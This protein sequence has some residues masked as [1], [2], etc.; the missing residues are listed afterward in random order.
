MPETGLTPSFASLSFPLS[1]RDWRGGGAARYWPRGGE[2]KRSGGKL[3]FAILL[4][5]IA[6]LVGEPAPSARADQPA[7]HPDETRRRISVP[8]LMY[9]Y[10]SVPPPDADR[11]RLDLSV[12]PAHFAEQLA[13]L[14]R[15]GYTTI[16]LDDLYA[17]LS[18]GQPLPPRPV[19]LTF[20][21]GYADAYDHAFR[22]LRA[23]GMVGTFFVVT[24]WLDAR[25]PG[26]L[27]WEQARTMARAGMAIQSH[28][29]SH[30]DLSVGCDYDC[31][32]YQILGSVESIEAQIG[33]RPRF[34]CYPGGRYSDAV[35]TVVD[36]VGIAAA[37]TTHAG[38]RHLSEQP[39]LLPRV[40]IR[41]TTTLSEFKWLVETG[42]S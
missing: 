35:L 36:Q 15:S 1:N 17:A 11:Y 14:A 20:D 25:T 37:V 4:A 30:P 21:D 28:S 38:M 40:R 34:F 13:W 29:R 32:V 10:I 5:L 2:A 7:A 42:G 9:H 3:L 16:T 8:V 23:R 26:Y 18:E 22:L 19:A 31:L 33:V 12:T 39:L 24:E 27:T 6:L 41:G